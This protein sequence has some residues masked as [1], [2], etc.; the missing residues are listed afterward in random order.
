MRE[1][2]RAPVPLG[3]DLFAPIPSDNPLSRE[4]VALGKQLF[5]D[6]LLSADGR[7]SCASCHQPRRSFSDTIRF[8]VGAHGRLGR[9]NAPS[10]LNAA[11]R[12]SFFWDGRVTSLEEQVLRPIQDSLEM[13]ARLSDVETRLRSIPK[14][15]RAFSRAFGE[16]PSTI[17]ISRALASYVRT[18][19]SGDAPIDRFRAGDTTA[20]SPAARAGYQLF[21]GKA[22][23]STCHVGPLFTDGDFHNSGI[24]WRSDRYTDEGRAAVTGLPEDRG[25]FKTP[26]LRNVALTAPY[27]H[28]GSKR[29]LAEVVEFYDG[30]GQPNPELDPFIRPLRLTATEKDALV[31]FLEMLTSDALRHPPA[32]AR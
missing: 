1:P 11:Y 8:S 12:D 24:A 21:I 26:S 20:V 18:L 29:S 5:A 17:N 30:G 3:L 13:D 28:D 9:R 22:G 32:N 27:M 6:P 15:R 10:L 14:Y 7:I 2:Y 23:C 19:R 16:E 25:R 4:R 31:A